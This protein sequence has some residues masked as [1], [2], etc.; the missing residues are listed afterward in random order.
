MPY[1]AF[2]TDA[3]EGAAQFS[4]GNGGIHTLGAEGLIES[5]PSWDQ[6]F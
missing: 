6:S 5:V 2:R 4:Y 3:F 1:L